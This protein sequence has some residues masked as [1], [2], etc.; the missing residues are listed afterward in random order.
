MEVR[1]PAGHIEGSPFLVKAYDA[2]RV[3]V[4]DITDGTVSKPVSFS[5]NASQAGAGN[6]EIIVAVGGRNVP[7]FV[8]SEGN[9]RFKVNFKPTEAATHTLSVRFNGQPVPGSPFSCKVSP[10]NA[11]P[12]IPVSGNGIELASV[13]QAAEVKIEGVTS[14]EPQVISTAPTGKILPTKLIHNGDYYI[15]RFTPEIVGRHSVAVLINDQHVIG[16]PFSCNVYDVNKVIVSGLPGRKNTDTNKLLSDLNLNSDL[17]AAE[18]GKPVTFSVDAAQ[19]GEGTLELVV[20]T[21]HTTI[22]AEVVAC[23]RGLYDVTFVPQTAEDHYVNITFNDMSVVGS[24]FHCSVIEATQYIQIG[25][26]SYIDLPSDQ[27]KLEITDQN[28]HH[29]KYTVNNSKAEF[30]LTQTGTFKVQIFKNHEIMATRTIHVFDTSKIDIINAPEA[31][32]HRP[33][34]IGINLNKVGPGKLSA[35]VKV[36]NRD[37]AHSVR[38]NSNNP[39]LWE[40]V[41]HPNYIAPHR[42][43]IYYNNVPK[44]GV[45]EVPVKGSGN[46]PWAGGLGLYQARVSKVT[47]FHIDTLGRSAREFDVVVSGPGGSAVPVRCYQTKTGKLQAEFTARE[48]GSHNVEVLHQAK[49]ISGS[50]FTCQAFDSERI[51]IVDIPNVQGNVG[52]RVSFNG[53]FIYC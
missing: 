5:I 41:F 49:P 32:C 43:T 10:G 39:N 53:K 31:Q 48:V 3:T 17:G 19:A 45:L 20:S 36:G 30:T 12:R 22:K 37:V 50:P 27:H 7:N 8:Q 15:A 38:Q 46:E 52:E 4:T 11:Q 51:K 14:G 24:P 2:N 25:T 18:V 33:A 47:S 13:G 28:N 1:L 29:V 6:L 34:V 40:I 9:A 23:A 44:F 16:S 42:I 26:T 35:S 21:Q